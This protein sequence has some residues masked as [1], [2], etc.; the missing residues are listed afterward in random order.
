MVETEKDWRLIELFNMR[1]LTSRVL[2]QGTTSGHATKQMA[3]LRPI[4]PLDSYS[5]WDAMSIFRLSWAG[6]RNVVKYLIFCWLFVLRMSD[7]S[8]VMALIRTIEIK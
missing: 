5:Q 3:I 7:V 2:D 8:V 1:Q 6:L 4:S